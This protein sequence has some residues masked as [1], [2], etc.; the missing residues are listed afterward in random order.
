M[1]LICPKP[2]I[3]NHAKVNTVALS[4]LSRPGQSW[5]AAHAVLPKSLHRKNRRCGVLILSFFGEGWRF[6]EG[7]LGVARLSDSGQFRLDF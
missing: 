3:V 7:E 1:A 5:L 4:L 2:Y 6:D